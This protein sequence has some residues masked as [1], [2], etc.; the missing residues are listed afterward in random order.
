M[1]NPIGYCFANCSSQGIVAP[2]AFLEIKTHFHE[3]KI[4]QEF[5]NR[6]SEFTE[7]N[8]WSA[9]FREKP[10]VKNSDRNHCK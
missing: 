7:I 2:V 8:E 5:F 6:F 9:P 3:Q 10:I 4:A 1:K